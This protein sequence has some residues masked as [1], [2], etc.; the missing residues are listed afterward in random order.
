MK[1]IKFSQCKDTIPQTIINVNFC[2]AMVKN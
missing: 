2:G 1:L